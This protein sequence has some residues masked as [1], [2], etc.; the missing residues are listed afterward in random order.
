MEGPLFFPFRFRCS[1]VRYGL[2]CNVS[3]VLEYNFKF[4]FFKSVCA[5][6]VYFFVWQ[7]LQTLPSVV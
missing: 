1:F 2:F 6:K 4:F 7:D 5:S 3:N